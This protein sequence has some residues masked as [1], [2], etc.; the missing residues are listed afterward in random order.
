MSFKISTDIGGTFTDIVVVDNKGNNNI[1]KS[2][3]TDKDKMVGVI[4]GL[5]IAAKY[6]GYSL[7]K[8]MNETEFV[9]HGSTVSTNALIEGKTAKVGLICTEGHRDILSFREGGKAHPFEWYIDYPDPYV[10]RYLTLEVSER[11]NSEGKIE[12]L[13]NEN[14]VRT[15]VKKLKYYNVQVIAVSLLWSFINTEHELRVAEIIHE[16]WPEVVVTLSHIVN[17]RIREYRRT[18]STVIDASLKP[19]NTSYVES[20]QKTLKK[21]GYKNDLYLFTSSG[22]LISPEDMTNQ[23]IHSIDSGPSL[24]P[25]SGKFY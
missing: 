25:I 1:F 3:T 12:T 9:S 13:L 7:E 21:I 8:L 15:A 23:P 20:L 18:V 19:L 5:K 22:G 14:E 10:P 2:P 6:Y 17:P 24:A 16:E 11:I 4:E